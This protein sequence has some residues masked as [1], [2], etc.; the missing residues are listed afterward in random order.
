MT[1]L[2]D[3]RYF[4]TLASVYAG[5]SDIV[6]GRI[7]KERFDEL[8]AR[9]AKIARGAVMLY[10]TNRNLYRALRDLER[11]A[12]SWSGSPEAQPAIRQARAALQSFRA[13]AGIYGHVWDAAWYITTRGEPPL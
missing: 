4:E 3:D 10:F 8:V 5:L 2:H 13:D 12:S 7:E 1:T 11:L 9:C 6:K